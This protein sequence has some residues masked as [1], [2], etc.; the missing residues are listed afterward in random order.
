[1]NRK[2]ILVS[3]LAVLTIAAGFGRLR[4]QAA[5]ASGKPGLEATG[6]IEARKVALSSEIGGKVVDVMVDEGDSVKAGTPLIRLDGSL[7]QAQRKVAVS[8]LEAAQ[9]AATTSQAAL[10]AAQSQ[11]DIALNTAL[12]QARPQRTSDWFN[13]TRSDF[14][15][16]TWYFSQ[17]EQL[18]AAQASVATAQQSLADAQDKLATVVASSSSADFVKAEQVMAEAQANYLVAKRLNDLVSNGRDTNDLTRTGLLKLVRDTAL[19]NKGLEP[20]WLGNNLSNDLRAA[21]QDIFD[22]SKA[23]LTA[24]QKAYAEA[25]TTDG[26]KAVLKARAQVSM[27]EERYYMAQDLL[28]S[29]QTGSDSPTVTAAQRALDQARGAAEQT[30]SAVSQA[31]ANVDLIDTQI[32]KLTIVAPSDGVVLT[33]SVEPGA[34]ALPSAT[35]LEVGRLESL[36]LTVYLPGEKFGLVKPGEA[37]Q[38][39]VDTYPGRVFDGR[40]LRMANEAEFTPTNVQTKEDRARLVYAVV[41]RVDNPDLELKPGMIADVTFAP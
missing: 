1:M 4:T 35:L 2:W 27:A 10:A 13:A 6:T 22:E 14:T 41:I 23:D 8:A 33:R 34:M 30:D 26:A 20:R 17:D 31:Q 7:L 36:E 39:S 16:P 24:S 5:A 19:E 32:A 37:V 12:S 15:K 38:V 18:A 21:A 40:V 9:A 3:A 29:L 28:R 11:Y 25:V